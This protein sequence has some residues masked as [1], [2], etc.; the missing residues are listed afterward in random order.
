MRTLPSN[1]TRLGIDDLCFLCPRPHACMLPHTHKA[2]LATTTAK[3]GNNRVDCM[4][5]QIGAI[6]NN[7]LNS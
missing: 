2:A 7:F 1:E 6:Y 5:Y 3:Q 4:R